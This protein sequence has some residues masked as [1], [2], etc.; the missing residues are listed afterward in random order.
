MELFYK[1]PLCGS[2]H[3]TPHSVR[4]RISYP[5]FARSKCSTCRLVF[6]NPMAND[7]ELTDFYQNYYD[8]GNF[9]VDNWKSRTIDH[10]S[11]SEKLT[12][13]QFIE[14]NRE[15]L[16]YYHLD[17]GAGKKFLDIG[18]G[19][20]NAVYLAKRCE[21][22][23]YATEYDSDAINFINQYIPGVQTY[24]GNF[25]AANYPDNYFDYVLMYHVIEHVLNPIEVVKELHRILK[26]GGILLIGTP[27]I[28]NVGYRIY[29]T[30]N[31]LRGK[32]PGIVDGMEHTYLFTKKRLA[33]LLKENKFEI[34]FHKSEAHTERL[35]SILKSNDKLARKVTRII[36]LVFKVNQKVVCAKK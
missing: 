17:I 24:Q 15:T 32:I 20:G 13:E 18:C 10:F 26:P 30:V 31:F 33:D 29:R 9:S 36:Q 21:W 35:S 8:A 4:Y 12:K 11:S 1:C 23:V 16:K 25:I 27:N 6:A 22:E 34:S 14:Q 7:D 5:H 2:D 3:I 28:G 19:L